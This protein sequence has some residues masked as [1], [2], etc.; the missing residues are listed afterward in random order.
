MVKN[1]PIWQG[2]RVFVGS[3]NDDLCPVR[4]VTSYAS[5]RGP[6][7]GAF[8]R[9][10]DGDPLRPSKVNY[11]FLIHL[12]LGHSGTRE[13]VEPCVSAVYSDA[14]IPLG[15][16]LSVAHRETLNSIFIALIF[17]LRVYAAYHCCRRY[18]PKLMFCAGRLSNT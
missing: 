13:I 18:C 16:L 5:L 17:I 7:P 15:S 2:R 9:I 1:R 6:G 11:S 4:A 10:A 14:P 12:R 3:T 8:F